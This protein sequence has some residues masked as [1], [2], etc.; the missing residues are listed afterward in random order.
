LITFCPHGYNVFKN[1]YP[2][3]LPVVD[4]LGPEEKEKIRSLPVISH[5]ELLARLVEQKRLALRTPEELEACE[6]FTI[7]DS[8]YYARYNRLIAEPR[9]VL[10]AALGETGVSSGIRRSIPFA[11]VLAAA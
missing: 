4:D 11:A 8:C 10:V 1:D 9:K 6:S 5:L 3:L 2:A 7:H